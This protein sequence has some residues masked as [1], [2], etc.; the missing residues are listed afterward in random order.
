MTHSTREKIANR[1]KD[2]YDEI[3]SLLKKNGYEIPPLPSESKAPS[4]EGEAFSLAYPIQGILKYHGMVNKEHRIAYFPSISINNSAGNTVTFIKF[5]KDLDRDIAYLNGELLSDNSYDRIKVSLDA[6]RNY[7]DTKA[8]AIVVTRNFT[9]SSN[10]SE[11]GK[12]LGT[13]ASGAAALSL[14]AISILYEN[15]PKFSKNM[16]LISHF[17][18]YLAGSGTRS[19]VGGFGLWL[20]HPKIDPF[21]S[22]A[23]RLDRSEHRKFVEDISLITISIASKIKTEQAHEIAPQSPFF[24]RWLKTRKRRVLEFIEA[25]N[26]Q[27]LITIGELAEYDTLCLNSITMTGSPKHKLIVWKPETLQ[28]MLKIKELRDSGYNVYYSIDTGPS[29]VLLTTNSEK[30]AIIKA[31]KELDPSFDIIE[32][33]IEG[34]AEL[35][36]SKSPKAQL[37][38]EDLKKSKLFEG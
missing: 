30:D 33:K 26:N 10:S 38:E 1:L 31:L 23:I 21:D 36:D 3:F 4:E 28:I 2:D 6:I 29:V 27:D 8:K 22:Y 37:L 9:N 15:D 5:S 12:G 34:P 11:I 32:G 25:L 14:G 19:A 17:S 24:F 16:R 18:R 20:S 13:S 35:L 7:S